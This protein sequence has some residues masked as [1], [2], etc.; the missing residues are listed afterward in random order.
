MMNNHIRKLS[1]SI[2]GRH[3]HFSLSSI[4]DKFK[5]LFLELF[6]EL[7]VFPECW[8]AEVTKK[9]ARGKF[10][11]P[12]VTMYRQFLYILSPNLL[13]NTLMKAKDLLTYCFIS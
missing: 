6:I 7:K 9:K 8:N 4:F 2:R 12:D 3:C 13:V 5:H 1:L 11:L 10:F